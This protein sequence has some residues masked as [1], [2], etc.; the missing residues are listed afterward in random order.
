MLNSG[1]MYD[2]KVELRESQAPSC[3]PFGRIRESENPREPVVISAYRFTIPFDVRAEKKYCPYY[4][5]AFV[6]R[7]IVPLLAVGKQKVPAADRF[8][9]IIR[10]FLHKVAVSWTAYA[11]VS[12]LGVHQSLVTPLP[13]ITAR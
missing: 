1:A 8:R 9:H 2:T 10:L 7:Y 13:A 12:R 11:S 3:E 4:R 6:L 5:Q